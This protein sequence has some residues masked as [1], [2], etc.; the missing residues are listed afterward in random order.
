ML[1]GWPA[2]FSPL[3]TTWIP[4]ATAVM[5]IVLLFGTGPGSYFD[6]AVLSFHVPTAGSLCAKAIPANARTMTAT[7]EATVRLKGSLIRP[8][9][10]AFTCERWAH[11]TQVD[12]DR[13]IIVAAMAI[14]IFVT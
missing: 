5:V 8:P 4:L 13:T 3:A 11:Y 6:F 2:P 9:A 7:S 14:R 12:E 1:V 10:C